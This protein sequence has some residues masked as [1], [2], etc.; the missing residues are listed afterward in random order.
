MI[1]REDS[2]VVDPRMED[3]GLWDDEA[4]GMYILECDKW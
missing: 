4:K 2:V 1:G 3:H